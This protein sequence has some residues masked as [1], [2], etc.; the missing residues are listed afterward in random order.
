MSR[1]PL[2]AG[3]WKMYLNRT[4]AVKLATAVVKSSQG[5][6]DREVMI[7]PAFTLLAVVA[8]AVRGS[9]VQ[10]GAQNVAWEKEG[11]YTGEIA[12]PMLADLGVS[13]VIVGHS[14][15]RH[16]FFEDDDM[17]NSRLAAALAHGLLP[18]LCV[19]ETLDER[20]EGTTM[21]TL[22]RQVKKGLAGVSSDQ[23]TRVVI[24][25]EPVWAIGTGKTAT[26]ELAQEVHCFLRD[27]LGKVF[28]KS[29]AEKVRILY[30]GSVKPENIDSLMAQPDIDGALVGGAA[31]KSESFARIIHFS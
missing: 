5:L 21:A 3:N 22:E 30:G 17:V 12:P 25:Y 13:M 23:I 28:E 1:K 11:A 8:D 24:A 10:L 9:N 26:K 6:T 4:E 20:E 14:E 16:I 19:G 15:R 27:L 2:I 31:L 29:L 18:I 7:A